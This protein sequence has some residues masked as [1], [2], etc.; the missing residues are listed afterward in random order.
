MAAALAQD[1][2]QFALGIGEIAHQPLVAGCLLDRVEIGPLDV[3]EDREFQGGPVVD[4]DDDHRHLIEAR[5]LRRPPAPL[6]GH[7][8]EG[9]GHV[10]QGPHDDRLD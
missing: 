2:R 7:D 9:T 8:L 6:A 10:G 4:L 3:F 5:P 1:L